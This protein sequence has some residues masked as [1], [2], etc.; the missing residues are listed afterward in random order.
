VLSEWMEDKML[1]YL[2]VFIVGSQSFKC[3]L[4]HAKKAF[5]EPP[6]FN[7][8]YSVKLDA[9]PLKKLSYNKS[10]YLPELLHGLEALNTLSVN[11]FCNLKISASIVT[12]RNL[13]DLLPWKL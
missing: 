7:I 8:Q 2:G 11:A 13:S 12:L 10:K 5:L 3:S 6:I 4:E 9:K 1:N